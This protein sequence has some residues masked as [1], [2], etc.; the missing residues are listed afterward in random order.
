MTTCLTS[1]NTKLLTGSAS[2]PDM[3][4]I[5]MVEDNISDDI[6]EVESADEHESNTTDLVISTIVRQFMSGTSLYNSQTWKRTWVGTGHFVTTN[7]I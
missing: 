3:F 7:R 2:S 4:N 6:T 5:D 1:L